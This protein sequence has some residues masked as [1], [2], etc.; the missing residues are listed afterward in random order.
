M[1]QTLLLKQLD[2]ARLGRFHLWMM[3]LVGLCWMLGAY[4]VTI[5]GFLLPSMNSEWNISTTGLGLLASLG[6]VGMMVGSIV[7][8]MFSDRYG[9]RRVMV[10]GLLFLG[11]FFLASALAP[12]YNVLLVLRFLTGAGFGAILPV[13]S[14]YVMEL[15]PTRRRGAMTVILNACWGLGGTVSALVGYSLVI[16]H[17]W[18][19]AMALGGIA[20]LL[21]PVV[22][23]FLPESPRF[24][25]SRNRMEQA[26]HEV[27]RIHLFQDTIMPASDVEPVSELPV[28]NQ[29][30]PGF[31]SGMYGRITAALWVLW[32]SLNFLY[33]GAY[34]WL[35]TLLASVKVSE[36]KS[37]LLTLV[38]S[39][40]QLP[41]TFIVAYLADRVS[42][43]KLI[44]ISLLLL[45]SGTFMF[46]LSQQDWWIVSAGFMLMVFNGMSWGIAYPFSSE[47]YPTRMRGKATGWATGLGRLGGVIA[48]LAIGWV[49]QAGGGISTVFTILAAAPMVSAVILST[50][51][52]E[53]TGRSLEEISS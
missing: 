43:K 31:L 19:L 30:Q 26:W 5:V 23:Y 22:Q 18:R 34:I 21:A 35:P 39:L 7:A 38:I 25:L 46:G 20:L 12:S 16:Q 10:V 6:M 33:Q 4:G 53:T 40:G 13:S 1:N 51:P 47:L 11:V 14:T 15:S 37:Y 27:E 28:T 52:L 48:P 17:G 36:G 42:R 3:I 24:L 45:A 8:G 44:I 49:V 32:I 29:L 9:R 2:D 41:G 50:I